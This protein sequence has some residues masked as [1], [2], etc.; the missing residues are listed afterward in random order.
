MHHTFPTFF[1]IITKADM[2]EEW[3]G[4]AENNR[5]RDRSKIDD[6][7]GTLITTDKRSP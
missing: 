7:H 6:D 4:Y 1:F 3:P 5:R 2:I